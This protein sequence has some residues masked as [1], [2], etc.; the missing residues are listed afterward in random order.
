MHLAVLK[1]ARV[2]TTYRTVWYVVCVV[3]G[4]ADLFEMANKLIC[5]YKLKEENVKLVANQELLT[6]H[7][8]VS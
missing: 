5:I 6:A 3:E 4:S 2:R 1:Q 8:P 7:Q